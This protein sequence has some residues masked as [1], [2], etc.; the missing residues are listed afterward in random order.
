MVIEDALA[1]TRNFS[2]FNFMFCYREMNEVVHRLAKWAMVCE[3]NE[4]WLDSSPTWLEDVIVA[5]LP[6]QI[7]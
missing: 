4:V 3:C 6:P 5:D 2:A 7:S 1:L